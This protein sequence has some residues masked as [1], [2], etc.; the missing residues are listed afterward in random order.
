MSLN[1]AES[2]VERGVD[3]LRVAVFAILLGSSL[4]V[5]TSVATATH[6]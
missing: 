2:E 4:T 5:A 1:L 3:D 6:P